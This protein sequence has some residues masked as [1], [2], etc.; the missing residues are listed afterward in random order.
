MVVALASTEK[1]NQIAGRI[2]LCLAR[3][4][5]LSWLTAPVFTVAFL[6]P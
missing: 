6:L 4:F 3:I 5:L 1:R 2:E